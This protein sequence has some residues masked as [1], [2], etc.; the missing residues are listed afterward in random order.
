MTDMKRDFI[1]QLQSTTGETIEVWLH[2]LQVDFGF[3]N[4]SGPEK[5]KL[6]SGI[7]IPV[8]ELDNLQGLVLQAR[9]RAGAAR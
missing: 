5:R 4:T 9:M 1:G 6:N 7:S 3:V 2:G 8:D